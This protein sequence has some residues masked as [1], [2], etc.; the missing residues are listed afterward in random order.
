M[1]EAGLVH[2]AP[3]NA[4]EQTV[5]ESVVAVKRNRLFEFIFDF[6]NLIDFLAL[7]RSN[8]KEDRLASVASVRPLPCEDFVPD[9]QSD[10]CHLKCGVIGAQQ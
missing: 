4:H 1:V 2:V 9:L 7:R 6:D 5:L 8:K 10:Y 3:L